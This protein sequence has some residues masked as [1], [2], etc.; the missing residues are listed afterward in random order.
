MPGFEACATMSVALLTQAMEGRF[1]ALCPG[2]QRPCWGVPQPSNAPSNVDEL[3]PEHGGEMKG[4]LLW[5]VG[6]PIPII[7]LLY[8]FGF[9]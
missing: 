6:L 8:L 2:E 7:I 9:M 5:L 1:R 4:V 3:C